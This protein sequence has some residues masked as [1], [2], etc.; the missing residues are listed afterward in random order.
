M[1]KVTWHGRW[2][3]HHGKEFNWNAPKY[4]LKYIKLSIP[5]QIQKS[6]F[7]NDW[8]PSEIYVSLSFLYKNEILE[9][10]SL[11]ILIYL[12]ILLT[13]NAWNIQWVKWHGMADE[14][15]PRW[16]LGFGWHLV[17]WAPKIWLR[18][19]L[20][21]CQMVGW[22][23]NCSWLADWPS[24][25]MLTWTSPRIWLCVRLTFCQMACWLGWLAIWQNV[26]CVLM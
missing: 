1:G 16:D 10:I 12:Y 15:S 14:L 20:I 7:L 24:K 23:A 9:P 5:P 4:F 6:Q 11:L 19:R 17:R 26:K 3:S 8:E 21:F 25:K 18:V 13:G 22:L 2:I